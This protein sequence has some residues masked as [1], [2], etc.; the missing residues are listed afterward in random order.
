VFLL[1]VATQVCGS[2]LSLS[3]VLLDSTNNLGF[4]RCLYDA[5]VLCCQGLFC[6]ES[7]IVDGTVGR[8]RVC[9]PVLALSCGFQNAGGSASG[10]SRKG[11]VEGVCLKQIAKM[12]ETPK[13]SL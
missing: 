13:Q 7:K 10:A 9:L 11:R 5:T 8:R 1:L 4:P 6:F 12:M 3:F 2:I